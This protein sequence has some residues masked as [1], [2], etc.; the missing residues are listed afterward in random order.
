MSSNL[1]PTKE[2]LLWMYDR[3][4]LIRAYERMMDRC[5]MEGKAPVFDMAKGPV[6]GEMHLSDGQEPCA[7]GVCVHLNENDYAVGS[8]RPHHVAIAKGVNLDEMTAEMFG[9]ETGLSKGRGGHMHLYDQKARFACS[10]IVGQGIGIGVGHALAIKM[11]GGNGVSVAWTG[12]GG[13]NQGI[14]HEAMNLAGLWKL[15][16]V[17]VIEDNDWS[18]SVPK[19]RSTAVARNSDRAAGYNAAG[20]YVAANDVLGVYSAAKRAVDRARA[21]EGPTIIEVQTHRLVG[22]FVGDPEIYISEEKKKAR[23]D[24]LATLR[25]RLLKDGIIDA[26]YV[27]RVDREIEERLNAAE[28]FA[29]SSSEPKADAALDHVFF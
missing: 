1:A 16:Y 25:E 28:S 29:R 3:M 17:L 24:P 18:V 14:F 20:E 11:Q 27:D 15:P 10:G 8:H 5:Y 22:H 2:E 23:V 12:E 19:E 21:G 26:A 7:V 6:P 13:A 9:R 4:A